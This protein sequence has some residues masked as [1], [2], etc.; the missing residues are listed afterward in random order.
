MGCSNPVLLSPIL[1]PV[2]TLKGTTTADRRALTLN[3]ATGPE[4]C[5]N[6]AGE[7]FA[8]TLREKKKDDKTYVV[9]AVR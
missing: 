2:A 6:T 9:V 5:H 8:A 7:T 3:S 1:N 4:P